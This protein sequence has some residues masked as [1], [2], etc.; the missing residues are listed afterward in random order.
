MAEADA[1]SSTLSGTAPG[2]G[3]VG[4]FDGDSSLNSTE[5]NAAGVWSFA[6]GTMADGMHGFT[7]TAMDWTPIAA[8]TLRRLP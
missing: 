7:A 1:N 6:S 3:V 5:S 8:L 2:Q 4:L